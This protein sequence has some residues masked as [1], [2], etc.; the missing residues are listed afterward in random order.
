M[1]QNNRFVPMFLSGKHTNTKQTTTT[2]ND[3]NDYE[4]VSKSKDNIQSNTIANNKITGKKKKRK[5]K[6]NQQQS[7][8]TLRS[9]YKLLTESVYAAK[10]KMVD[11]CLK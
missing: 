9:L 4:C 7:L 2:T 6:R 3:Y 8:Q 1:E 5:K 10:W 11:M